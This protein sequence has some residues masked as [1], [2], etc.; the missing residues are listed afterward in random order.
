MSIGELEALACQPPHVEIL[1]DH[2]V[3]TFDCVLVPFC[4]RSDEIDKVWME[5][6]MPTCFLLLE[7]DP[8]V[9]NVY[10]QTVHATMQLLQR[11]KNKILTFDGTDAWSMSLAREIYLSEF[12]RCVL[13]A[14]AVLFFRPFHVVSGD[15]EGCRELLP[16]LQMHGTLQSQLPV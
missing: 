3:C 5:S 11:G 4:L 16:P 14:C 15:A 2:V 12:C 1:F 6:N 10:L 13:Q 7:P 8:P 9:D